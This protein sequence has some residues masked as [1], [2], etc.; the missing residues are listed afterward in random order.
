MD[1]QEK[2]ITFPEFYERMKK[3]DFKKRKEL[4]VERKTIKL[5]ALEETK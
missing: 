2:S 4:E 3:K 5:P 1:G